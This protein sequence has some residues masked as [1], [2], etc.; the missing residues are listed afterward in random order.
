MRVNLLPV[1]FLL[2]ICSC[3][4]EAIEKSEAENLIDIRMDNGDEYDKI[5]DE[6]EE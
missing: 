5:D 2:F 3:T 1:V 6:K 4:P